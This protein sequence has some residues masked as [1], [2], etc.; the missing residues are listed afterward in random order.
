MELIRGL[1]NIKPRHKGCMLAIGNFDGFHRG[2]QQLISKL[3]AIKNIYKIPLMVMIFEPQPQEYFLKSE[4]VRL[5]KFRDKI[6]Y[7]FAAGVDVIICVSF[8]QKLAGIKAYT[9]IQKIL[10]HKLRV[11][12]IC[13]GHDFKFGFFREGDCCLLKKMGKLLGFQVIQVDTCLDDN[14]QKISS[15]A[16]KTALLEDRIL[17]AELMLGHVYC[18]SGKVIHG[19]S[20]GNAI[21]FPTIN[22]SLQGKSLPIQGV[23]VVKVYGIFK[24]S[25]L[26]VANIGKRPS[27]FGSVEQNFE[28]HLLNVSINLYYRN[29]TVVILEKIRDEKYFSSLNMLKQQIHNDI[30]KV[31]DYFKKKYVENNNI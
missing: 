29:V 25:L 28:V 22:I 20:L 24:F 13:V 7:L 12:S 31:Y 11:R 27:I 5:T 9:F 15:T 30:L 23:Y 18:I 21:G 3:Y 19:N 4:T 8:N 26:G 10:V 16:I 1:H 6:H 17:D 2:H 14:F